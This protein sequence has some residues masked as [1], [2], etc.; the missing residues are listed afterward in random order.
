MLGH[1][2]DYIIAQFACVD[3]V[4]VC[5][6]IDTKNVSNS[7][8]RRPGL[9]PL[10][11]SA[12]TRLKGVAENRSVL[13]RWKTGTMGKKSKRRRTG[14]NAD[15]HKKKLAEVQIATSLR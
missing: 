12:T 13:S 2:L 8:T 7:S 9:F 5:A 15:L 3:L 14:A 10:R 1:G 4:E 11:A 6:K